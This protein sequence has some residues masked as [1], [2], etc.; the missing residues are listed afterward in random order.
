ML[1]RILAF[2]LFVASLDLLVGIAGL[3][4]LG[5]GGLL[6]DRRL[7]RRPWR[8]DVTAVGPVQLVAAAAGG[9][10]GGTGLVTVRSRGIYFLMLTLAI[11]ELVRQLADSWTSLTGGANGLAG[12]PP[13]RLYPEARRCGSPALYWYVLAAVL[14]YRAAVRC[15]AA[16]SARP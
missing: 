10:G 16:P 3:P 13:L 1:A 5:H 9:R 7:R 12:V 2:G 8:Q 15:R 4:S 6:R 14:A 11:G